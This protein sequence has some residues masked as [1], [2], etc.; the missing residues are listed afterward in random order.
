MLLDLTEAFNFYDKESTSLISIAH[1]RNILY[2]FGF[3][4]LSKREIDVEL[5]KC[6]PEFTK[7]NCV[8]LAFCKYVVAYRWITRNGREE[9]A[10]ECWRVFDKKDRSVVSFKDIKEIIGEYIPN[11]S[12]EDLKDFMRE[13]DPQN[14]GNISAKDF[15][16]FYLS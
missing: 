16:K 12:D 6:D 3:H 5:S 9:E 13:I 7:R 1:F 11:L 8:D 15:T 10:K 2:N 14:Q 4:R